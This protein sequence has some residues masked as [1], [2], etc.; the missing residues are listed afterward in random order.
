[1]KVVS[2]TTNPEYGLDTDSDGDSFECVWFTDD[3]MFQNQTFDEWVLI[4]TDVPF[5]E[6]L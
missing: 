2:I 5:I 6:K 1:M 3:G 4:L